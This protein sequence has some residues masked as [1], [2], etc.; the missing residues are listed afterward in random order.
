MAVEDVIDLELVLIDPE[1]RR[2]VMTKL[3]RAE[4]SPRSASI[5]PNPHPRG[6]T[7]PPTAANPMTWS[8]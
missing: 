5:A 8:A 6:I 3:N 1:Y 7:T 4:R 2:Q